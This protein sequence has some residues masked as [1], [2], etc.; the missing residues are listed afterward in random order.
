MRL[1]N[2]EHLHPSEE[3]KE[4]N[5]SR[6]NPKG[7]ELCAICGRP[8]KPETAIQIEC[9][10]STFEAVPQDHPESASLGG[11][12]EA[13]GCWIVGPTCAKK[14]PAIYHLK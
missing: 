12:N 5:E 10:N 3:K 4:A 13:H 11:D 2:F 7:Y 9:T 14:I 6:P 1:F 8:A